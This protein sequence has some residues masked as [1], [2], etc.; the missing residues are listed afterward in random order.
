MNKSSTHAFNRYA[1]GSSAR[2]LATERFHDKL[3]MSARLIWRGSAGRGLGRDIKK[4]T[5]CPAWTRTRKYGS[6]GRCV[7]NY[8]TGQSTGYSAGPY[9]Y[10]RRTDANRAIFVHTLGPNCSRISRADVSAAFASANRPNSVAPLPLI[11][12]PA[13][14]PSR[15]AFLI[16]SRT[17]N[18]RIDG[19]SNELNRHP[20]TPARSSSASARSSRLTSGGC[21]VNRDSAAA[22]AQFS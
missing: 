4:E 19:A 17:G 16:N 21:A 13:A 22:L 10:S 5:G 18:L 1:H 9:R 15:I 8:T 3:G 11:N 12:A 14:P 6:K 20:E 2:S 7:T